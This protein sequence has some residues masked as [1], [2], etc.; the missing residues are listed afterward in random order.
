M[1]DGAA[2]HKQ[3]MKP[4]LFSPSQMSTVQIAAPF[5]RPL[6]PG[7][8]YG[9]G[10]SRVLWWSFPR[11]S[12]GASSKGGAIHP[13]HL[14]THVPR[15]TAIPLTSVQSSV[16]HGT[17]DNLRTWTETRLLAPSV[18]STPGYRAP[19]PLSSPEYKLQWDA[20][21]RI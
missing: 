4:E 18:A 7:L 17:S 8:R 6:V 3:R 19:C 11:A 15:S 14:D 12:S 16:P 13:L 1:T 10:R 9:E 2:E 5:L 21:A 20:V